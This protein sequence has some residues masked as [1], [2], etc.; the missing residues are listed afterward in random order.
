VMGAGAGV[1]GALEAEVGYRADALVVSAIVAAYQECD[2]LVAAS[3]H[4]LDYAVGRTVGEAV[5][6]MAPEVLAPGRAAVRVGRPP[7]AE[8]RR[9][10][11]GEVV[12]WTAE[13]PDVV[14]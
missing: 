11:E 5:V 10:L 2:R 12:D 13:H 9:R 14:Q 3:F 4:V 8:T 6:A 1:H 7:P